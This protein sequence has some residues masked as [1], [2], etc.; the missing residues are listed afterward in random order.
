[1]IHTVAT[2]IP[3]S[4]LIVVAFLPRK[5]YVVHKGFLTIIPELE[6]GSYGS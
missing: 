6:T 5:C 3:S 2:E 1:M 4:I